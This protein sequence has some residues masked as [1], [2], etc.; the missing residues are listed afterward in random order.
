MD[1]IFERIVYMSR[2]LFALKII[3]LLVYFKHNSKRNAVYTY[4][5]SALIYNFKLKKK[6]VKNTKK[7][8]KYILI[9]TV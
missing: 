1:Y 7:P 2:F 6:I 3:L 5:I 8:I 4:M 9:V